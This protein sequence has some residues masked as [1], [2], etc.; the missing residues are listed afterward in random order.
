M[1]TGHRRMCYGPLKVNSRYS[2]VKT[3]PMLNGKNNTHSLF[4]SECKEA[5]QGFWTREKMNKLLHRVVHR[6]TMPGYSD[7]SELLNKS[8]LGLSSMVF[9][10][11]THNQRCSIRGFE[12]QFHNKSI[13]SNTFQRQNIFMPETK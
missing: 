5:R 2:Q 1:A 4:A 11:R 7:L 3:Q 10:G 12:D 9:P 6:V 8:F 13:S